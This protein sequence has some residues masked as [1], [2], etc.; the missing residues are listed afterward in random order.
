[1]VPAAFVP[2][3]TLPLTPNGKVD[4]KA[5]P[6]P[7]FEAPVDERKLVAPRTPTEI[8]LAR[9]WCEVL[10][11]KQVGIRDNFFELGGHSILA[12]KLISKINQSLGLNLSIPVFFQNPTI[13]KL[14]AILDQ[15]NH[16]ERESKL[17]H[18]NG[19]V[20]ALVTYQANGARPPL[21]FLHGDW[22]G[23]GLYCA[24]LS[25]QLGEDQ[26]FY[27]L[28][29]YRSG[30]QTALGMEK[31]ATH[32][33]ATIQEQTPHGPYLLGGYC[34]GAT[35]AVEIARQ[36]V[37]QGEEV[38]HLLLIEPSLLSNQLVRGIWPVVD[39]VGQILKWDLKRKIHYF[40]RYG[41]AF[42]F[43][44]LKSPRSKFIALCHRLGLASRIG[45]SR[46]TEYEEDEWGREI[47][48]MFD[49]L[50]YAIYVLASRLY[51]LRSLS[52]PTTVYFSEESPPSHR[53]AN[54]AREISPTVRFETVPGDH[55]TCLT[56]HTS[57]L[58]DKLKKIVAGH[59]FLEVV[60]LQSVE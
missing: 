16:G 6:E 31:M 41:V 55:F 24:R 54:R 34:I 19:V 22:A 30:K 40:H 33:I 58:A 2:L 10:G 50:D 25:Q 11:L 14:A 60:E 46:V 1:M 44:L 27:A 17:I 21:F 35:V 45:S 20:I 5:L 42:D 47:R 52:V 15:E 23:G 56:E 49:T 7:H 29:P 28:S 4:R 18:Q 39:R 13:K 26:P 53:T 59:S 36:L 57:E 32:Y 9:I 51:N 3:Q 8:V 37:E 48:E 43:W 38:I 12:V